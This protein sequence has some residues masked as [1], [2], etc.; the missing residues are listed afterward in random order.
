VSDDILEM[1]PVDWLELFLLLGLR[2]RDCYGQELTQKM[3]GFGFET[4][5]PGAMY[6]ALRQMEKEGMVVS[7]RDGFDS[8]LSRWRYSIT[9]SGED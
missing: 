7:E 1:L 2:E 3:V 4:T 6:W 9:E 8:R 5:R